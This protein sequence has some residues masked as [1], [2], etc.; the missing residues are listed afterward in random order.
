MK[1][2]RPSKADRECVMNLS[3][4]RLTA[5]GLLAVCIFPSTGRSDEPLEVK[6]VRPVFE[7]V[8]DGIAP[9][10]AAARANRVQIGRNEARIK[11][12]M[13]QFLQQLRPIL[14]AELAFIRQF[15]ELPKE[16]RP[17]IKAAGEASLEKAARALAE[18]Q[19]LNSVRPF[20]RANEQPDPR[21]MICDGLTKAL[22]ETLTAEAMARYISEVTK[23]TAR[24]KQAAILSAVSQLDEALSLDL[25]QREKIFESIASHWQPSWE[26][27]LLLHRY[28]GHY[29]PQIPD[30]HIVSH[31]NDLQRHVWDG[32]QKVNFGGGGIA[33]GHVHE[34]DGWWGDEPTKPAEPVEVNEGV[35]FIDN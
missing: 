26:Q 1:H 30:Q 33:E 23:R 13:P 29:F 24:R 25:E 19:F 11:E 20:G 6:A 27:W 8:I 34:D 31:L 18:R 9:A 4:W 10:R 3:A 21:Q 15:C 7:A 32:L 17:K 14:T 16:Q 28:G 22:E 35:L 2:S 5:Y 12:I